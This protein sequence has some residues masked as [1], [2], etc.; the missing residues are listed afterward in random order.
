MGRFR[1]RLQAFMYGRYGIDKLY[2]WLFGSALVSWVI[3]SVTARFGLTVLPYIFR[4]LG[5]L[6]LCFALFRSMSKNKY[7]RAN[8][9]RAFCAALRKV[10]DAFKLT[11]DRIRD[12]NVAV[13]KK[14]PNC[15]A[16]LR[17]PKKPGEHTVKCPRCG[18][19][20]DV[21]I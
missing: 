14:C 18:T 4:A 11:R 15:K 17:L 2:W 6:C 16:N 5:F 20:F 3:Q 10:T 12:R 7:K 19:R 8:E 13:F 1:S 9:N 21:K